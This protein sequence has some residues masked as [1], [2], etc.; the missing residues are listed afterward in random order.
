MSDDARNVQ[1]QAFAGLIWNRQSYH[2]DVR[3][4]LAGDSTQPPHRQ[5]YNATP[6]KP[7]KL[8]AKLR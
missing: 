6:S 8:A 3:R 5:A 1:R 4:W 7:L 2:Y